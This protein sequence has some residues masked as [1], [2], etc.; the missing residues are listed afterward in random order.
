MYISEILLQLSGNILG[1]DEH[2][3]IVV[4]V[5]IVVAVIVVVIVVVLNISSQHIDNVHILNKHDA[6]NII[7]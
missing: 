7:S 2:Y 1:E 3:T 5:V 4:V 6:Y